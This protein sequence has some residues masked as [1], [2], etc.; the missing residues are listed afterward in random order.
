MPKEAFERLGHVTIPH[1]PGVR[2]AANH[3]TVIGLGIFDHQGVLFRLE[4]AVPTVAVVPP[5]VPP[6][7]PQQIDDLIFAGFGDERRGAGVFLD[8][9]AVRLEAAVRGQAAGR[10]AGSSLLR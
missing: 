9:L 3:G 7:T 6:Q 8:V 2:A 10:A 1:V 4:T 5:Q